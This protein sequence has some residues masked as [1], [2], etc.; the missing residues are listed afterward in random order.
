MTDHADIVRD[1]LG[2]LY[3]DCDPRF[4][5]SSNESFH[6]GHAALDRLEALLDALV[7]E[8][9]EWKAASL[10]DT[11]A[12]A[13]NHHR[14]DAAEAERDEALERSKQWQRHATTSDREVGNLRV[15]IASVMAA[16]A[17]PDMEPSLM[18]Q[19]GAVSIMR[20][21]NEIIDETNRLA[22]ARDA[23]EAEVARLRAIHVG[24]GPDDP[25]KCPAGHGSQC[26]GYHDACRSALAAEETTTDE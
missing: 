5:H 11:Q 19:D 1:S 12:A 8:R 6:L 13:A 15:G 16:L 14:A 26:C 20:R 7:A 9:D 3:G 4:S 23:A 22:A 18:W 17:L 21:V 2:E 10:A 25:D 24:I